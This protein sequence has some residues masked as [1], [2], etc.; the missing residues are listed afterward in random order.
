MTSWVGARWHYEPA[1][2][3]GNYLA[4]IYGTKWGTRMQ[5]WS[6]NTCHLDYVVITFTVWF[7]AQNQED[8]SYFYSRVYFS[9]PPPVSITVGCTKASTIEVLL[10]DRSPTV[11]VS[12]FPWW[13]PFSLP[14]R[15]R[16]YGVAPLVLTERL[17]PWLLWG[18]WS[19]FFFVLSCP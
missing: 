11:V 5:S 16:S 3:R 17:S 10:T 18:G 4:K 19:S 9:P 12:V 1:T 14:K 15:R 8:F 7:K 2:E 13:R 6:L